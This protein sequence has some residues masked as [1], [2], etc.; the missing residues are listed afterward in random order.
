MQ[1][2]VNLRFLFKGGKTDGAKQKGTKPKGQINNFLL[3][4]EQQ[5][6]MRVGLREREGDLLRVYK[7]GDKSQRREPE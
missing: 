1:G 7:W 2:D 5:G 6:E 4:I 3:I